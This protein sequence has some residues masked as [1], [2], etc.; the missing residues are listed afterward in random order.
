MKGRPR[1]RKAAAKKEK[2]DRLYDGVEVAEEHKSTPADPDYKF[3][4][5]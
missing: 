5:T 4:N 2:A 1:D 3:T